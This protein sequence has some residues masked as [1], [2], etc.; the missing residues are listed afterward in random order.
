MFSKLGP[1][2]LAGVRHSFTTWS[3]TCSS[4]LLT[5]IYGALNLGPTLTTQASA[6]QTE[7]LPSESLGQWFSNGDSFV[8][9]GTVG[10]VCT[11]FWLS[12]G[13]ASGI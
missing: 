2:I 4:F 12:L 6:K 3:H 8:P 7:S 1:S 9:R 10:S 11:P 5:D 13:E